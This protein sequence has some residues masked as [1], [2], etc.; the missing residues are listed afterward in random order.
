ML[1]NFPSVGQDHHEHGAQ[2]SAGDCQVLLGGVQHQA[3]QDR[4]R[5]HGHQDQRQ[6]E[7]Q[8]EKGSTQ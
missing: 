1:F 3:E 7:G 2:R 6:D 5:S 4:A 8:P